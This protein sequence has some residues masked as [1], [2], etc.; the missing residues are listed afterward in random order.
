MT[1]SIDSSKDSAVL[2]D[3]LCLAADERLHW[4]AI[5]HPRE[6]ERERER[7]RDRERDRERVVS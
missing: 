3:C 6:R 5:R 2:L 1:P 4:I 7:E